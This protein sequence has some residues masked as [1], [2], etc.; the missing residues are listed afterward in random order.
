M[1]SDSLVITRHSSRF[2]IICSHG[3]RSLIERDLMSA[4][5]VES[6]VRRSSS[7]FAAN[8]AGRKLTPIMLPPSRERFVVTR[9]SLTGSSET[10]NPMW[11]AVIALAAASEARALRAAMTLTRRRRG[12]LQHG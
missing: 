8:S 7:P 6:D 11:I 2:P 12:G 9:P 5:A 4:H 1:N 10:M 3:L